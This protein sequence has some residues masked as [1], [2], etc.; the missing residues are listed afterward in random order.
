MGIAENG[1]YPEEIQYFLKIDQERNEIIKKWGDKMSFDREQT[2]VQLTHVEKVIQKKE[3]VFV[4]M[5]HDE[6][7]KLR[8]EQRQLN[9]DIENTDVLGSYGQQMFFHFLDG[10]FDVL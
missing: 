10:V 1:E 7:Q 6:Y 5:L 2:G 9:E 3:R 8:N 4:K